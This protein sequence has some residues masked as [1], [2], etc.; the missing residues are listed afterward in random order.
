MK[1][2]EKILQ[3][4]GYVKAIN[5]AIQMVNPPTEKL[6]YSEVVTTQLFDRS[7]YARN[8]ELML[9]N[10]RIA[11]AKELDQWVT[12]TEEEGHIGIQVSIKLHVGKRSE[13]WE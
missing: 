6:E 5:P 1:L 7:Q 3:K 12:V 10:M 11:M 13:V 9:N 4:F 2:I 8:K